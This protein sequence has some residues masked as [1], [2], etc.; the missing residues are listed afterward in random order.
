MSRKLEVNMN[1]IC[2][3]YLE[4]VDVTYSETEVIRDAKEQGEDITARYL[5]CERANATHMRYVYFCESHQAEES[6]EVLIETD[7]IYIA[8]CPSEE[9]PYKRYDSSK[10]CRAFL[11][12]LKNTFVI[13]KGASLKIRREEGGGGYYTVVC[14]FTTEHPESLAFAYELEGNVPEYWSETA[15]RFLDLN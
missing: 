4:L 13:P 11:V 7:F 10:V 8:D 6:A 5:R 9:D 15:K 12:Q 1:T 14:W 2:K 3:D